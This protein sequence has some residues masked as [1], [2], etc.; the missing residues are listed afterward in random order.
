MRLVQGPIKE[1]CQGMEIRG[2]G[3]G[4]RISLREIVYAQW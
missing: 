2:I 3:L 1:V 4:F